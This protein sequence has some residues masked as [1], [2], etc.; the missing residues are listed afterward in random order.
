MEPTRAAVGILA[1]VRE[2][3][4]REEPVALDPNDRLT[5]PGDAIPRRNPGGLTRGDCWRAF[6]RLRT[7]P[8]LLV[9][10]VG[11]LGLRLALGHYD[12][13]DAAVVVGVLALTPLAE[14]VI[15]VYLLHAKPIRVR[16]RRYDLIAA[17]EHRAHHMAP[18]ELDGV[19]IPT[20]AVLLFIPQIALTVWLLSF[21]IHALVGGDRLAHA[22]TGLL[23]SYVFLGVYEWCH[24]LIHTP[25]RPRGRY[26]RTIWRGHR[27]HHYKNEHF[28]FGVTSTLGDHMLRTAPD[29]A[30]V[31]KSQTARTLG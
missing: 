11:A 20:Y 6:T 2:S 29:Q 28:W 22:A 7:P 26:Y 21:P 24:F 1:D 19:L 3:A 10:I 5:A 14:W 31:P 18:A 23:T 30:T 12:W 9:A 13:R 4:V 27:L 25:Y 17:R 16:G 15:H 8:I